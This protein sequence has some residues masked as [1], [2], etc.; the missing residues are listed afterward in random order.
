MVVGL[1]AACSNG[2]GSNTPTDSTKVDSTKVVDTIKALD[3]TKHVNPDSMW[4]KGDSGKLVHPL[5]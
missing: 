1:L 4:V 2:T 3:T 5:K